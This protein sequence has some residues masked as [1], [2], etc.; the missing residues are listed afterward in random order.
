MAVPSPSP[1]PSDTTV[2]WRYDARTVPWLRCCRLLAVALV[3]GTFASLYGVVALAVALSAVAA[4]STL[5]GSLRFALVLLVLVFVGGP[6]SLLYLLPFLDPTQRAGVVDTLTEERRT[7]PLPG[8]TYVALATCGVVAFAA[9]FLLVGPS[10]PLALVVGGVL[11]GGCYLLGTTHGR[12]DGEAL[13]ATAGNDATNEGS[14]AGLRSYRT[15]PL[16]PL[17]LF[18]LRHERTPGALS[19]P[20]WVLV[21]TRKREASTAV[22]DRAVDVRVTDDGRGRGSNRAVTVTAALLGVV[23]LAVGVGGV[24]V[25][26][27]PVGWYLSLCSGLFG[28]LLLLVAGFES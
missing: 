4:T 25:V 22:F 6:F 7:P 1:S 17:S 14:L 13:T 24:V 23:L 5:G 26:G 11:A 12:I 27:G 19:R 9:A 3:G 10:G 15:V 2:E 18:V 16:G 8:R 21:P 28:G 20:Q